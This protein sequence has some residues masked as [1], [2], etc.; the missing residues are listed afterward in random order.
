MDTGKDG[1]EA[2]LGGAEDPTILRPFPAEPWTV[3]GGVEPKPRSSSPAGGKMEVALG[4]RVD[5]VIV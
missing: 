5:E 2:W 4:G 3:R 1:I